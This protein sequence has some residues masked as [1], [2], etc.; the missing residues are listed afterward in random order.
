MDDEPYPSIISTTTDIDAQW[1]APHEV[2]EALNRSV[3]IENSYAPRKKELF[4][5]TPKDLGIILDWLSD[6]DASIVPP[7]FVIENLELLGRINRVETLSQD[8]VFEPR[9]NNGEG[10]IHSRQTVR[11]AYESVTSHINTTLMPGNSPREPNRVLFGID[12]PATL[13]DEVP[14]N[15][16]LTLNG[17]DV[18][19]MIA[20][21]PHERP[22]DVAKQRI[23]QMSASNVMKL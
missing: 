9:I 16:V 12:L 3:L 10:L 23:M 13:Q 17:M 18:K 8:T 2:K 1:S 11:R 20:T 5:Q 19:N 22:E 21:T 6:F 4:C 7:H 15:G 14:L